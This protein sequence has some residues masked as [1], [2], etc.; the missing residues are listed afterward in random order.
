MT[1]SYEDIPVPLPVVLDA[2]QIGNVLWIAIQGVPNR[3][4]VGLDVRY[5]IGVDAGE[6]ELADW[7][8]A[9]L[10]DVSVVIP[11]ANSDDPIIGTAVLPGTGTFR[12]FVRMENVVGN[13][14]DIQEIGFFVIELLA[15]NSE[16]YQGWPTWPGTLENMIEWPHDNLQHLLPDPHDRDEVTY[17]QW[18]GTGGWPFGPVDGFA[19]EYD[20]ATERTSYTSRLIV[21]D[22]QANIEVIPSV[23][24]QS[25]DGVVSPVRSAELVLEHSIATDLSNPTSVAIATGAG[26]IVTARSIRLRAHL[27]DTVSSALTRFAIN[28][29]YLT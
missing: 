23:L 19:Q 17:D 29:R 9:E 26:A 7:D 21:L 28:I 1:A 4:I 14:S 5:T 6:I 11:R 2:R 24:L 25:P 27:K 18:N 13:L 12:L 22:A 16:T 15:S 3:D 8:D 10:M 20:A